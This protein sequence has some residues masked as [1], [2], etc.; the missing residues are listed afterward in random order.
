MTT[1]RRATRPSSD[2]HGLFAASSSNAGS[3]YSAHIDG[4]ARGNPGP[5]GY[6]A[7]I[8]EP[9]G[10]KVAELSEY[11][12]HHTN[13]YA[14]YQGLLGVLRYAIAQGIQSLQVVSDSELMV[15]QM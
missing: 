10:K 13:N 5:S 15:R 4:G 8:Q 7:V 14:E 1:S 3:A 2:F 6:G 11:L 9:S 12:G